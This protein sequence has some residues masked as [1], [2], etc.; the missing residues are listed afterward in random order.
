[1]NRAPTSLVIALAIASTIA[2]GAV[3]AMV[4]FSGFPQS[5]GIVAYAGGVGEIFLLLLAAGLVMSFVILLVLFRKS[6][7]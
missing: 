4:L 5:D 2:L 3:L 1:M 6:R 7:S